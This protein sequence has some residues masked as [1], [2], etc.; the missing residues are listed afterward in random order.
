[1]H[2]L[3][4]KVLIILFLMPYLTLLAQQAGEPARF[5]SKLR[6]ISIDSL[7]K[8]RKVAFGFEVRPIIPSALF[9]VSTDVV[10]AEDIV[11]TIS[12]RPGYTYGAYLAF[13]L[14]RRFSIETGINYI[15]RDFRITVD[16]GQLKTTLQF[17]ADNYEIPLIST[18][19]VR[20]G[21]NIYMGH[22]A[23]ISMQFLPSH[24]AS[25]VKE[26]DVTGTTISSLEQVSKRKY[27]IMP[28]F[29]GGIGWEYRSENNGY[30]YVGPAY[31]LF[32]AL[33]KT[34][35]FYH[36]DK[37]NIQH[38]DV[39]PIGDFFGITIRYVFPPTEM[40]TKNKGKEKK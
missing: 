10:K 34:R 4:R 25:I 18:Y 29:K 7:S 22:S 12:P 24:L 3:L 5:Q 38:L 21:K 1:M 6:R 17:T 2:F 13:N 16:D 39:K 14:S 40:F 35:L 37:V 15:N 26:K 23:G 8:N 33:Y 36:R 30:I 20:L 28:A 32:T 31:L 9:R 27:W 19:Y 11:F